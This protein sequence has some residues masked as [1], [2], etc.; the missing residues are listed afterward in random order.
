VP[1][2]TIPLKTVRPLTVVSWTQQS[3]TAV[4]WITTSRAAPGGRRTGDGCGDVLAVC[5]GAGR[6]APWAATRETPDECHA[7]Y[8]AK[9]TISASASA[10]AALQLGR[11]RSFILMGADGSKTSAAA[12]ARG[13]PCAWSYSRTSVS[14]SAP[15]TRAML[16]IC[17]RA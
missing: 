14:A 10:I 2:A 13:A 15:T 17:P 12:T 1:L 3:S 7:W 6:P 5:R 11:R 9:P 8:A 4:R 16:R